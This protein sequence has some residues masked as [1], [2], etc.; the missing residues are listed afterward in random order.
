MPVIGT[1]V[2]H[3]LVFGVGEYSTSMICGPGNWRNSVVR[4]TTSRSV[5]FGGSVQ[6]TVTVTVVFW[7]STDVATGV[8]V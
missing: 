3:P 4:S 8:T 6:A 5:E 1:L 7:A 2:I